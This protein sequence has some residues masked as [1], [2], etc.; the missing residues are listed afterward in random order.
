MLGKAIK[1]DGAND[2]EDLNGM[3]KALWEFIS[4]IYNSH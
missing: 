1:S 3:G 4:T 2:V